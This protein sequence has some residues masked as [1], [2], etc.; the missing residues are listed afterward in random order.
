MQDLS[1]INS[2]VFIMFVCVH[3]L[4][5]SKC[6]CINYFTRNSNKPNKR[7]NESTRVTE[8]Y[9]EVR[10]HLLSKNN[11][12]MTTGILAKFLQSES[13]NQGLFGDY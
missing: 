3:F 1:M 4:G 5:V 2:S 6:V 9:T 8:K 12:G 7:P 13:E 11:N 10:F